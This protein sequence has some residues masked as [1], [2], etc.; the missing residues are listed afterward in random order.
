[1]PDS[2]P[3]SDKRAVFLSYASQDVEV[4]ERIAVALRTAG[5]EVW[6]D[7][8]ELTGGDAWD[9]KI[10]GQIKSCALFIP[11]ISANT[12]SRREGYFRREWKIAVDR[13]H[14]MDEALPFLVPV[15]ID[16]TTDAEAFVPEKFREMQWTRLPGCETTEK[17]CQRVQQ[18]LGD[19]AR[20]GSGYP[21]PFPGDQGATSPDRSVPARRWAVPAII[22]GALFA[23]GAAFL[24]L[25]PSTRD[26]EVAKPLARAQATD[27]SAKPTP[28]AAPQTEVQKLLARLWEI[29]E[30]EQDATTEEWALAEDLGAQAVK[31]EPNN[32]DAWAAYSVATWG[33][34]IFNHLPLKIDE[35]QRR[36]SRALSLSPESF[37]ARLAVANLERQQANTIDHAERML[38]Q[39]LAER[40]ADKR[41]L[42]K[43]SYTLRDRAWR[44]GADSLAEEAYDLLDRAAALP[45]GDASALL[46]KAGILTGF[47]PNRT[48]A[49]AEKCIDAAL[50]RRRGPNTLAF[51]ALYLFQLHGK[52]DEA[53]ALLREAPS[54]FWVKPGKTAT[55]AWLWL[56]H[57]EPKQALESLSAV[58]ND[59]LNGD[60]FALEFVGPRSALLGQAHQMDGNLEAAQL[61]WQAALRVVEQRLV[62]APNDAN[63]YFWQAWLLASLGRNDE[64]RKALKVYEQFSGYSGPT[65]AKGLSWRPSRTE[66]YL[67]LG[68]RTIVLATLE[69][70]EQL[71]HKQGGVEEAAILRNRLVYE[72]AWD[73][74]RGDARFE[75]LIVRLGE[76]A[77]KSSPNLEPT[78]QP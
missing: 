49:D 14:D 3:V 35:A 46:G 9:T 23:A 61:D 1:M 60:T 41:V 27:A 12:N 15:V 69:E 19:P 59:F 20:L 26:G 8:S 7:R 37:E 30:L 2:Q 33:N 4:V 17:F 44:A 29:H 25:R 43:L 21:H 39:L 48:Y 53:L 52:L 32:A 55:V 67:K 62:D 40:P 56:C 42:R 5:V 66:I 65:I 22:V 68:E 18:L 70:R 51:K 64:A 47:G 16:N 31:L 13:T 57:R 38:R 24:A 77:A 72:P 71:L 36:A 50:L 10:R 75:S 45:G 34:S 73:P 78:R 11:V 28:V 74:L 6:F 63:L 76:F 54:S 58:Q